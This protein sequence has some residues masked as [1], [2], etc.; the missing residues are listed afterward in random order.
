MMMISDTSIRPNIYHPHMRIDMVGIYRLLFVCLFLHK[1]FCNG[2]LQYGLTQGDEIWQDDRAGWVT[3]C[4]LFWWTLTQ[5]LAP[6]KPK[7]ENGHWTVA[8]QV[9]QTGRWQRCVWLATAWLCCLGD[10][11]VGIYSSRNNWSTYYPDMPI[12]MLECWR[13]IV[14]CFCLSVCLSLFVRKI[15]KGI[16]SAWLK[17]GDEIWQDGRPGWIAGHLPFGELWPR[18]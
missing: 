11:H 5:G 18:G 7:S 14:Y 13:Y 17:Q 10:R 12:G 1:K 6:R 9:W 16:S 2:Y 3:D 4:L 8:S 15:F